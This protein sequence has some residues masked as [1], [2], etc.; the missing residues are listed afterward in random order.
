MERR[1]V[2]GPG[3]GEVAV[4]GGCRTLPD[5][6]RVRWRTP[7][8]EETWRVTGDNWLPNLS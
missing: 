5:G 7:S 2:E 4:G 1:G 8:D 6:R 3:E